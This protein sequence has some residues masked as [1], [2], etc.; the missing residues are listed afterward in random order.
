MITTPPPSRRPIKTHISPF[1]KAA[2]RTAIRNELDR[3][4]QVFYVVARIER[5]DKVLV[6]LKEMIPS[7]RIAIAHGQMGE[8]ELE[9]TMLGF[10]NGDADLLI[11]TTI[12][13]SGLD[14][15]R[16]NTIIIESAHRFGLSQLYQLRGRVGRI[17]YSSPC[18]VVLF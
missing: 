8:G 14:I 13:E 11:C 2:I 7:L 5:I 9:S 10:N 17:G 15:P 6:M 16:V 1:K 3:G 18:L 4:G 12:I